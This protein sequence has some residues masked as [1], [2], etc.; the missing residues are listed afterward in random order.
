MNHGSMDPASEPRGPSPGRGGFGP[1]G[2]LHARFS[3]RQA[4]GSLALTVSAFGL[5]KP[6]HCFASRK[7]AAPLRGAQQGTN[8]L[9]VFNIRDVRFF[10]ARPEPSPRTFCCCQMRSGM[11]RSRSNWAMACR[12]RPSFCGLSIN[13]DFEKPIAS[14]RTRAN[15]PRLQPQC[16]RSNILQVGFV[17]GLASERVG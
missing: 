8:S 17:L 13:D 3:R 6:L 2:V 11:S 5:A 1:A 15:A 9:P 14:A 16:W 12:R 10:T 4:L 7:N